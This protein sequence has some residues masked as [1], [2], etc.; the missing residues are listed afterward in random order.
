MTSSIKVSELR[1]ILADYSPDDEVD[2]M[3]NY[4]MGAAIYIGDRL[5]LEET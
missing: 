5:I 3:G 4:G 1:E 2:L